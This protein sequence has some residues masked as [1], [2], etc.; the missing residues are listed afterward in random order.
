V[1]VGDVDFLGRTLRVTRQLQRAKPADIE[2]GRNLVEAAGGITVVVR[3]PKYESERTLYLP[4]ELV[5]I[6]SERVRRHTPK[7]DPH[8][9]RSS[10]KLHELRHYLASGLIAA[11]CDVVTVQR[12]MGTHLPRIAVH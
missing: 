4:D 1:Q 6:L 11:A 9:R 8:R 2:A 5:T 3:P 12:A 10:C 7:G